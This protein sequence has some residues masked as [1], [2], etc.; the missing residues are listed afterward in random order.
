MRTFIAIEIPKEIQLQLENVVKRL[1]ASRAGGVRWVAPGNVHLTLKFI[2]ETEP[3]NL[4][5]LSDLLRE[6]ARRYQPMDLGIG[7]LGCFPNN[8]RPRVIWVGLDIPSQIQD[9]HRE[10]EAA[11]EQIG[12]PPEGRGF[13]PHLTLGRVQKSANREEIENIANALAAVKADDLG[14]FLAPGFTLYRSDLRSTGPIY[15]PL[16]YFPFASG[17]EIPAHTQKPDSNLC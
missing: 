7:G 10:I 16:G 1:R 8:K 3:Q 6:I 14:R 12:C 13:S 9:L 4:T 11:A 5:T 15:T 2:G 17:Q